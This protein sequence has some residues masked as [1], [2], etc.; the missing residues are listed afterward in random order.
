MSE[1]KKH[2][3]IHDIALELGISASTVSR[4]L[5]NN[6]R[7]SQSTRDAVRNLAEL[8]NYQPNTMAASLRKGRGNTVGLI[9]P[10]IN[11][12]FFSKIIG[13]IEEVLSQSGYNLM[14]CQS[15]ESIEKEK[16]ALTAL[17]NARVDGIMMSLSMETKTYDHIR[18]LLDRKVKM[19]F[20]DRIPPD[21]RLNSVV[22]NDHHASYKIT[23]HI[24]ERGFK[25]P[26]Y[27]GGSN[28]INVYSERRRGFLDA[29][30]DSG[31][32]PRNSYLI[33]KAMTLEAGRSAFSE[34]MSLKERP[35]AIICSGDYSAHG[36]L[37]AALE[38]NIKVPSEMAVSGFANEEFT[39]YTIPSLTSV[40]QKGDEIGKKAAEIFLSIDNTN[41]KRNIMIEPEIIFRESTGKT[42]I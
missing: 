20:L 23:R 27:V 5:Q 3:T 37:L 29:L 31:I 14:I 25:R 12:S 38:N 2:I 28:C 36:V 7:I 40:D 8:H 17:M 32:H 1:N 9:V 24:L 11:R 42:K 4:A 30:V 6:S 39:S 33:E 34:L 15:N 35:D 10:N 19:V 16:N 21:I 26:A 18:S 13:G 41:K 22:I